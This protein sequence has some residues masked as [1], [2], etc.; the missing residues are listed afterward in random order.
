[1]PSRMWREKSSLSFAQG[2]RDMRLA[3]VVTDMQ[4]LSGAV[5]LEWSQAV[6]QPE[7]A[8]SSNLR[9]EQRHCGQCD[10]H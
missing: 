3:G 9:E 5:S 2:V 8:Q 10:H 7:S 1:M 6:M 4:R